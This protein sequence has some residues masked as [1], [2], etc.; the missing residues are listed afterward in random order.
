MCCRLSSSILFPFFAFDF[1]IMS[2]FAISD[3]AVSTR[4]KRHDVERLRI[5]LS[6]TLLTQC[7][8]SIINCKI[9]IKVNQFFMFSISV[10][11]LWKDCIHRTYRECTVV[12]R[13][14]VVMHEEGDGCGCSCNQFI[15]YKTF[16]SHNLY[17][18]LYWKYLSDDFVR[19][20]FGIWSNILCSYL[21]KSYWQHEWTLNSA[22][23][24]IKGLVQFLLT[25]IRN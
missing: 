4:S 14:R 2:Q 17:T 25:S 3:S 6:N 16:D 12:T 9:S 11:W 23:H 7:F 8:R 22:K 20:C 13:R 24:T 1:E 21:D 18:M 10:I 19:N 15:W 5:W